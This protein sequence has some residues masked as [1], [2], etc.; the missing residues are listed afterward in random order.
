MATLARHRRLRERKCTFNTRGVV[1]DEKKEE[2][3]RKE[4]SFSAARSLTRQQRSR[5]FQTLSV[6]ARGASLSAFPERPPA[7]PLT[8]LPR[9]TEG[10]EESEYFRVG[11]E[12]K[13]RRKARKEGKK[14]RTMPIV[15][16]TL[17]CCRNYAGDEKAARHLLLGFWIAASRHLFL[18]D[19]RWW[20]ATA[21]LRNG[22]STRALLLHLSVRIPDDT[23]ARQRIVIK[24]LFCITPR[25]H[26]IRDTRTLSV[27]PQCKGDPILCV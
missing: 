16:E 14:A 23:P 13:A 1:E 3:S 7:L 22:M 5:P 17:F 25:P 12:R 18:Y 26:E 27:Y 19:N 6:P 4:T 9:L 15:G 10:G 11:E 2:E 20:S 21:I 8:R 24:I